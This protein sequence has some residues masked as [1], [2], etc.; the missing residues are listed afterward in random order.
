M[1]CIDID[2][3]L[4]GHGA[5]GGRQALGAALELGAVLFFVVHLHCNVDVTRM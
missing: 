4:L 2:T 1:L 3:G 5:H